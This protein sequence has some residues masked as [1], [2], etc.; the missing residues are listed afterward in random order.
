MGKKNR[1]AKEQAEE[2]VVES[3]EAVEQ[4]E[5]TEAVQEAPKKEE[6]APAPKAEPAKVEFDAWWAAR[7]SQ[8]PAVHKKEIIRA[9]M[10]GR[11]IPM[12]A[13]MAAFDEALKMYGIKVG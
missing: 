3:V 9:D 5:E 7:A 2:Q 13:T 4:A 1:Q 8:I 12:V 6:K 11:K 10:K